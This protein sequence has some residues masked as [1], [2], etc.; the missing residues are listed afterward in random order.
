MIRAAVAGLLLLAAAGHAGAQEPSI[1]VDVEACNAD[2][3]YRI[4][5]AMAGE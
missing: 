2:P 4:G 5:G 3:R 1:A